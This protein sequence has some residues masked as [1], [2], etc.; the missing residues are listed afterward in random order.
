MKN[1]KPNRDITAEDTKEKENPFIHLRIKDGI[2]QTHMNSRKL[3]EAAMKNLPEWA[4]V[5]DYYL[6]DEWSFKSWLKAYSGQK[7]K[8]YDVVQQERKH[9][10]QAIRDEVEKTSDYK[11]HEM[12]EEYVGYEQAIDDIITILKKYEGI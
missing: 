3:S 5:D 10:I 4:W 6:D 2:R 12:N 9:L 1:T 11:F 8:H 7:D